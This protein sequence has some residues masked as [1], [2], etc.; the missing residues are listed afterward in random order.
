M[1]AILITG[2]SG[3]IGGRLAQHLVDAGVGIRVAG[4]DPRRLNDRWPGVDAVELDVMR[5]ET[6]GPATEGVTTACYLIHS[7]EEGGA[8]FEERD[9]TAA[10][11][12]ARAAAKS[13]VERIVFLGGLGDDE[14]PDLSPHL[15]SRH[16]TGRLLAEH[17]PAVLELRAGMVIGAGSASFRMLE[18]LVRRLPVMVTPRWVDTRSQPIAIDDVVAYLDRA[19]EVTLDEH[20]T[21]VEIGGADVL[22]YREM[23]RRLGAMRGRVPVILPV[24]VLSPSLSSLWCGLVTSVPPSIARPLIEGQRNETIVRG[25]RSARLFP[26]VRPIGFD[27]A[28]TRAGSEAATAWPRR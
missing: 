23:M 2:A 3:Y 9:R 20:H 24:P 10:T 15:A 8:P 25:D 14:D 19:R 18:D 26:D 6:I 4:R 11:N 5:P 21:I 12:F 27:E 17:G 7:M 16:E 1:G 28:V 13:G 22:S